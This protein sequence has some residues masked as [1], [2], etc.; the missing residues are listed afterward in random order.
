[1]KNN[2]IF[3]QKITTECLIEA[4]AAKVYSVI[5]DFPNINKWTDD[6]VISGDTQPGGKMR[7]VV[8]IPNTGWQELSSI[9]VRMD[10]NVIAFNNIILFPFIFLGKHRY[11]I[12][13]ITENK[14]KFINTEEF[15]GLAIPFLRRKN[16]VGNV[17]KFKEDTNIALKK[18]VEAL[19]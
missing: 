12:I 2:S 6:L 10:A 7:V 14:T 15:S 18:A 11:E 17:H 13:P 1:M 19:D 8:N 16:F 9:M 4:S 5:S 3:F